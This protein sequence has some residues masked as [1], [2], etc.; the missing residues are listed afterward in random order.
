MVDKRQKQESAAERILDAPN[1][2]VIEAGYN[3]SMEETCENTF[4]GKYGPVF[5]TGTNWNY[6]WTRDTAMSVQYSLAWIYPQESKNCAL[7]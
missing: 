6:V 7:E 3:R 1:M 4:D 2:A 5:N